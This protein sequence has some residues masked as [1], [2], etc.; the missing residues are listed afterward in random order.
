[1][2]VR[3]EAALVCLGIIPINPCQFSSAAISSAALSPL[4]VG[5]HCFKISLK[6]EF[7]EAEK[8]VWTSILKYALFFPRTGLLEARN[9][10]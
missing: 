10:T 4:G 6:V 1:M 2:V 5:A 3:T 7:L 8:G 9:W